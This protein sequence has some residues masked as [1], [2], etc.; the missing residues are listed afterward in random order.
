MVQS[1]SKMLFISFQ[2]WKGFNLMTKAG[3]FRTVS[4]GV[5]RISEVTW[6][7]KGRRRYIP[8]YEEPVNRKQI[9]HYKRKRNRNTLKGE[10]PLFPCILQLVERITNNQRDPPSEAV[11][12][13]LRSH[14]RQRQ[15][16]ALQRWDTH[17]ADC[18][19]QQSFLSSKNCSRIFPLP[20]MLCRDACFDVSYQILK[21]SP[22]EMQ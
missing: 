8:K 15:I 1:K 19:R 17:V 12:P 9:M 22:F 2:A 7:P 6:R 14:K 4:L 20:V 18:R 3:F 21:I 11:E 16:N 5:W 10:S 13:G